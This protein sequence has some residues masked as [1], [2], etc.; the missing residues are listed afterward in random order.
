MHA[1][2]DKRLLD[3]VAIDRIRRFVGVLLDDR[4]QVAEQPALGRGQLGAI[5][6]DLRLVVLDAINGSPEARQQRAPGGPSVA[7]TWW[8]ARSA[9]GR[10]GSARVRTSRAAAQALRGA[11]ALLR[12]RCPSSCRR[13]Y[14]R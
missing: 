10:T 5:D 2:V 14:A 1:G 11:F 13:V 3:A 6:R 8:L 7:V 4:E 9:S 12:Y